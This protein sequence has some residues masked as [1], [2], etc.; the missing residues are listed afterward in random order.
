MSH[1]LVHISIRS[2][3]IAAFTA[4]LC[5]TLGLGLFAVQR[6]TAVNMAAGTIR[7]AAL[8]TTRVLGEVAYHTMRL[9]QLE[10]TYALAPD[11]AARMQEATSI[12]N[13]GTQAKQ[14]LEAL[15][16]LTRSSEQR[17]SA[18]QMTKKWGTYLDLES[19]YLPLVD[20]DAS[21]AVAFYR[22][23]MRT[24]FN[25]FQDTLQAEIT[26][27]VRD[28]KAAADYG[29]ELGSSAHN[30]IVG[31]LS[32]TTALAIGIGG[33][34]VRGIS[35]PIR[36]MTQAMRRLAEGDT[37]I[38]IPS[39]YRGDEV[40]AMAKAVEVF[41]QN[42]VERARLEVAREA[43]EQRAASEKRSALGNMAHAIETET[44]VAMDEIGRRT[45]TMADT[46]DAM[47]A[48]AERTGVA[49]Q[50]AATA[51]AQAL[52]NA[53]TVASAAEQLASSIREIGGQVSQSSSLV[54]R[55]VEAGA[56]TRTTIE[57]LNGKVAQIGTV[58]DMIGEIA[59]KTNLLALNATIEAARAGDAGKGFAVVASEVKQ[60]ATQTARSTE[61][62]TRHIG[63]VRAAT[64]ASVV[65]VNRIEQNITE[66]NAIA[67]SIAAAVEQQGAATAEIA[68]NVTETASATNEMNNR[69]NEVSAEATETG[70]QAAEVHD[71]ATRLNGA[72]EEL[73]HSVVRVVRTSTAEVDRRCDQ[74]YAAD[75][76]CR[77]SI[78][79]KMT[80][81]RIADL[82]VRG[83]CVRGGPMVPIGTR[84]SLMMERV[85]CPLPFSVRSV[86]SDALHVE[87]ELDEAT[88]EKFRAIPERLSTRH[89]A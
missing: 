45:S 39:T 49:A 69:I 31:A 5:C 19:K 3:V 79:G 25:Q 82:S 14:A 34:M 60:L 50:G 38:E 16:G 71:N 11:A 46:A 8:P 12:R 26:L 30:W 58:A 78:A 27:N 64:G 72:V 88:T 65:A 37:A 20:S 40:G 51:A 13:V 22:G 75:L 62:I 70:R 63:D 9:R 80:T 18:E 77:I 24:L 28:G 32:L 23:E 17:Q 59:A 86:E 10:A 68:R 66:I 87:F 81:A 6:L 53:Q 21:A 1:L 43:Q 56:E 83:G 48:S 73:K 44:T 29:T 41:K 55:A 76:P 52:A 42:A 74:R 61:E 89:A 4:V 85:D 2:K 35:S 36:G 47:H 33:L 57:T 67:S 15:Q 7:D 54:G 84:G